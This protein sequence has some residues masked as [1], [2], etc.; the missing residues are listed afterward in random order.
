MLFVKR[1]KVVFCMLGSNDSDFWWRSYGLHT[2]SDARLKENVVDYAEGLEFGESI[3]ASDLHN[4]RE[5][6]GDNKPKQGHQ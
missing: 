1:K 6:H 2:Y 3:E 4:W 5:G